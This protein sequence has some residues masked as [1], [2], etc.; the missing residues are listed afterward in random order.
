MNYNLMQDKLFEFSRKETLVYKFLQTCAYLFETDEEEVSFL[1]FPSK[2]D[3]EAVLED[4]C[5]NVRYLIENEKY[6]TPKYLFDLEKEVS[7]ILF[8]REELI[9]TMSEELDWHMGLSGYESDNYPLRNT[10]EN[11]LKDI[12]I[13]VEI[14]FLRNVYVNIC[15]K[16]NIMKIFTSTMFLNGMTSREY[17]NEFDYEVLTDYIP[18]MIILYYWIN[19]FNETQDVEYI[20]K[21][22][23][24]TDLDMEVDEEISES[25]VRDYIGDFIEKTIVNNS[26]FIRQMM[27]SMIDNGREQNRLRK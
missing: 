22:D 5:L 7:L 27:V 21:I 9:R 16:N 11:E 24:T 26:K 6:T 19:K 23:G 18:E 25:I 10:I 4:R 3:C 8:F 17:I 20:K 1:N 2:E 14:S 15:S 12:E 13:D